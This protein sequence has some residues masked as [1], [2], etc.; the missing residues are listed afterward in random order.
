[1]YSQSIDEFV[2][3]IYK[4]TKFTP[5]LEQLYN[6]LLTI[7]VYVKGRQEYSPFHVFAWSIRIS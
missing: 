6:M 2:Q 7:H 1:M 3:S 4:W 5:Q